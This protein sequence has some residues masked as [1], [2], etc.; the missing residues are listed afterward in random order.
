[1]P[2]DSPKEK[3]K[4][5]TISISSSAFNEEGNIDSYYERIVSVF[6]GL[7][8]YDFEIVIADNNSTD[9]T[10]L[11]L[12]KIAASDK[13][14]KV[15]LNSNNFGQLRSPVNAL[16]ACSGDAVISLPSDLQIPPEIIPELVKKWEEGYDVVYT[17]YAGSKEGLFTTLGRKFYYFLMKKFSETTHISNFTGS[18]LYDRK[19]VEA[20]RKYK[21][22]YPYL[23]GLVGEI[24]FK[25]AS[26]TCKKEKRVSGKTKN[27]F[28]TLY[29]LAITGLLYHS[30]VPMRISLFIGWT[31]AFLSIMCAF[32]YLIAKL[33]F[34]DKF[35]LGTAP[36]IIGMF[37][38]GAIQLISVGIVGEYAIAILTQTKNK[39]LVI[40]RERINFGSED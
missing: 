3:K 12:R 15:I 27:N 34:W 18:G 10:E 23:R 31:I 7:P 16:L 36:L 38:L 29:D 30:K 22:P 17:V 8:G 5:R 28:Y 9:D 40:E 2:T 20:L 1:M 19:F 14:F 25:Q 35:L 11:K 39:P 26:V 37:F 33:V 21:E 24:G 6:N 4:K 32:G 13:R